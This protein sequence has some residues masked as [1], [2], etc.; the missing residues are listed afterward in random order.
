MLI[1]YDKAYTFDLDKHAEGKT[2]QLDLSGTDQET[3]INKLLEVKEQFHGKY[4]NKTD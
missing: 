4:T 3:S 2:I 1:Y